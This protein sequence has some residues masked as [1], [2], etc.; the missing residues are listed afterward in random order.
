MSEKTYVELEAHE[1]VKE[2]RL[3]YHLALLYIRR[4]KS[5]VLVTAFI[6]TPGSSS[7]L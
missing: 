2:V 1:K 7:R 5:P 3:S 4:A 6:R